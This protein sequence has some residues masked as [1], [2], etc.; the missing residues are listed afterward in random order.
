MGENSIKAVVW[1]ILSLVTS[2][3]NDSITKLL[4]NSVTASTVSFWRFTFSTAILLVVILFTGINSVK[5]KN[6]KLHIVRGLILSLAMSLWAYGIK[7][8]TISTVTLMSF[9]VPM[10]TILMARIFL[11]EKISIGTILA[12]IIGFGGSLLTLSP[13]T[14]SLVSLVF[15]VASILFATLDII[16]KMLINDG[17]K[18]MPMLFYSNVFSALFA[19]F[20]PGVEFSIEGNDIMLL[21]ILGVGANLILFFIV[22]A[23]TIAKASFLA[24]IRY[25]ELVISALVGS[26]FFSEGLSVNIVAGGLMIILASLL[27]DKRFKV[28]G[29]KKRL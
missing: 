21:F 9:T 19:F 4:S 3:A 10:F 12:T 17:E 23:F 7:F 29:F 5:T 26:L 8:V 14:F 22:K 11:K 24:P 18:T 27:I 16:N 20:A 13:V 1:F 28:D 6:I 2:V 25:L 15:I